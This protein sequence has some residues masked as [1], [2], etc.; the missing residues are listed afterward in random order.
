MFTLQIERRKKELDKPERMTA[1]RNLYVVLAG[2]AI[3]A[4]RCSE[5]GKFQYTSV[6]RDTTVQSLVS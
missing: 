5:G 1:C 6:V 2:D 3:K 4:E